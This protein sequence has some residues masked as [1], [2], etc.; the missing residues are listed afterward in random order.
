MKKRILINTPYLKGHGGVVNHYVGLRP[1]W[2]QDV[3]YNVVG[4]R[5]NMRGSGIVFLVYDLLK[6]IAKLL[7]W[8]PDAV[9][10][11]PSLNRSAVAR[12]SLFL[13]LGTAL[14]YDTYVMFHGWRADYAA[15]V[16]AHRFASTFNRAKGIIVLSTKFRDQLRSW[17]IT[18][19]IWLSTT[20]V[21]D[22]L[23]EGFDIR[24]RMRSQIRQILFLSRIE[25]SKGIFEA[26][27]TFERLQQRHPDLTMNIVGDGSALPAVKEYVR[28]HDIQHVTF[29]GYMTGQQL[30]GQFMAGDL[31]L[32]PSYTEGMPTSVLEAMAFGLPVISRPVGGLTDFFVNGRMGQLVESLDPDDFA[33]A[34]EALVQQPQRIKAISQYNHDYA[35]SHF[36]ASK[37]AAQMEKIIL[38]HDHQATP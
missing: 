19:P 25:K 20:K 33:D 5:T 3:R 11:N 23:L 36:L 8:K 35:T 6:F 27:Q 24:Q 17:G 38:S 10:V 12:D 9:V 32:F 4:K 26:L 34:I 13:R 2:T 16:N 31:Y 7:F 21:D 37:V 15:Q 28:T 30:A 29:R 22:R 18:S 1:Y 14:G